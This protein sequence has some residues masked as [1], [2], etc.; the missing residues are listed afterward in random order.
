MSNQNQTIQEA[1]AASVS[2]VEYLLTQFWA[3]RRIFGQARLQKA[4]LHPEDKLLTACVLEALQRDIIMGLCRL[5]DDKSKEGLRSCKDAVRQGLGQTKADDFLRS[6]S[7]F[8][9]QLRALDMKQSHRNRYIAHLNL[10]A[11]E[12]PKTGPLEIELGDLLTMAIEILS[13]IGCK[14]NSSY[15]TEGVTI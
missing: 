9:D 14:A 8:N 15:Q 13:S 4:P 7:R 12:Q 3:F 5:E 11:K 10:P 2:E 6:I 1:A